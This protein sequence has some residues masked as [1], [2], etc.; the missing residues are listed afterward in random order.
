MMNWNIYI[1]E[2]TQKPEHLHD[3][4]LVTAVNAYYHLTG[5]IIKQDSDEYKELIDITGCNH[6]TCINVQRAWK[7]LGISE[8]KRFK[9]YDLENY[10]TDNVF[11]EVSIWYKSG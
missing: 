10:L 6:G 3:C 1:K 7:K 11:L 8:N 9:Y 2:N 5:N 4:Q